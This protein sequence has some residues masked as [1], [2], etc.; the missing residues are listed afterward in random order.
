MTTPKK[1]DAATTA[2]TTIPPL[3]PRKS[4]DRAAEAKARAKAEHRAEVRAQ[5]VYEVALDSARHEVH[6]RADGAAYIALI[7]YISTHLGHDAASEARVLAKV[8]WATERE[9]A[10][11]DAE[12]KAEVEAEQVECA[13]MSR[14][15]RDA[16]GHAVWDAVTVNACRIA[17]A[18]GQPG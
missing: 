13:T 9:A 4:L 6:K 15:Y 10:Q 8:A 14:Y 1:S 5:R 2:K 16:L 7:S 17:K 12:A 18:S 11:A 3:P